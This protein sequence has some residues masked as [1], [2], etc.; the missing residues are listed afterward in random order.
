MLSKS[1]R[2]YRLFAF[3]LMLGLAGLTLGA[4]IALVARISVA[5]GVLGLVV[6]AVLWTLFVMWLRRGAPITLPA[7]PAVPKLQRVEREATPAVVIVRAEAT[8][9]VVPERRAVNMWPALLLGVAC[10]VLFGVLLAR[11]LPQIDTPWLLALG[12]ALIAGAGVFTFTASRAQPIQQTETLIGAAAFV[13]SLAVFAFTR[14]AGIADFP[15]YF[16]SDEAI[17]TLIAKDLMAR[18]WQDAAGNL[19]PP[20]FANGLYMSLSLSV[21]VQAVALAIFGQSVEAVRATSATFALLGAAALALAMKFAFRQRW[22]WLVVLFLA[23]TPAWFLHS[24][25]GFELVLMVS[26]YAGF[27]LF[28]LL[29]RARDPRFL[30]PAI[31]LGALTFYSYTNGQSV[32]LVSGVL[33]FFS[34]LHYHLK[35]WRVGLIGLALIVL[36]ALP[37]VRFRIEYPD[38]ALMH[39]R[40]LDSYWFLP[41]PLGEK[42]MRFAGEYL[43]GLSPMFW[44]FPNGRDLDRHVMKDYG[45]IAL[46][47]LPFWLAGVWVCI[48]N[49]RSGIHRVVL[50]AT[51]AAPFGAAMA[52]VFVTRAMAFVVPAAMLCA[53]G[54]EWLIGLLR[55]QRWRQVAGAAASI[56]IAAFSLWMWNDALV[57]GPAWF[58]N[59]SLYGMQW[60]ARQLFAEAAPAYLQA[61]PEQRLLVSPSWANGT[62]T[63]MSFFNVDTSRVQLLNIDHFIRSPQ[64]LDGNTTLV[65][66]PEEIDRAN[67]S[68]KFAPIEV[69]QQ[70]DAPD[71]SPAFLFA[72]VRYAGNANDVFA[73]EREEKLKL[74]TS[75]VTIDG[76]PVTVAHS[77]L[78]MGQAQD[79]FDGDNFTLARGESANPFVVQFVFDP[80]RTVKGID[81]VVG[82]MDFVVRATLWGDGELNPRTY[83]GRYEGLPGEPSISLDF[84]D[85]PAD[86]TQLRIEIEQLNPPE[87][88]HIHVRELKLR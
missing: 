61:H 42:L 77:R 66:L 9:Y 84:P 29:Y 75:T 25:T 54:A 64:P 71:G 68:G 76:A 87:E 83:S 11:G 43:Y 70:V 6:C 40:V 55:S 30:L 48:R 80:P 38:A 13:A 26:C 44:F 5:A 78:D 63:L 69:V 60:G 18:G 12:V 36:V 56:A 31:L 41:I 27:L 3:A 4:F 8:E 23:A 50:I 34:D 67:A 32:M 39:L 45:H 86:I 37:F 20:Y 17:N 62:D 28:Y 24:R 53:L 52:E 1:S 19:L 2:F 88:V 7:M 46:W 65:M 72:H 82:R 35:H 59:Y 47:M 33:L 57:N 49:F 10:G 74:V 73:A 51:L 16:F 22:W 15:I 79:M 81:L 58:T 21:Y 14:F 85:A